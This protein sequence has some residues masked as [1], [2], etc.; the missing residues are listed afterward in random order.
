MAV[1]RRALVLI[2]I[3][4]EYVEGPLGIQYP[5]RDESLA[6]TLQAWD[7]ANQA[8]I[9]VVIVQHEYPAGT[10]VFAEGSDGWQLQPEIRDRASTEAK[11]VVKNYSSIFAETGLEQWLRDQEIDTVTLAGYMTNNCV[12]ASAAAAEPLGFSVEVLADAT[13]AV[14][15]SNAAGSASAQQVHETL[16]TLLHSNWAAATTTDAWTK[17]AVTGEELTPSNLVVSALDGRAAN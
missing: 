15:L 3:Q 7:A 10:P 12:L 14:H 5:P 2:D 8:G 17:A 11:R 4:Q 16:M 1:P 6:R 13:G 9:P